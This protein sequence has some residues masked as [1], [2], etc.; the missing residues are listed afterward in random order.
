MKQPVNERGIK[1]VKSYSY[2]MKMDSITAI[3]GRGENVSTVQRTET[4]GRCHYSSKNIVKRVRVDSGIVSFWDC[5]IILGRH[6]YGF[7]IARN[8]WVNGSSSKFFAY[9]TV[10][11]GIF[12]DYIKNILR[13]SWNSWNLKHFR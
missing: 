6:F 10:Y 13:K 3:A 9:D 1:T 7:S 5:L 11:P 8:Q 12:C 2:L 4:N